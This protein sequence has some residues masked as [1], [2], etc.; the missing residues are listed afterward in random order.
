M[1]LDHICAAKTPEEM[2]KRF[3][4]HLK[5]VAKKVGGTAESHR[6]TQLTNVGYF[7]GYYGMDKAKVICEWLGTVHPVFGLA[8]TDGTLTPEKAFEMGKALGSR[9]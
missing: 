5:D 4:Q 9:K 2:R 6:A 3:E 1:R 7:S 8:H